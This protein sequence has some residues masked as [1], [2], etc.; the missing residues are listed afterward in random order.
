[1][2]DRRLS[3]RE[4]ARHARC[5]HATIR[6]A[7]RRGEIVAYQ[8]NPFSSAKNPRLRVKESGVDEFFEKA[9]FRTAT[10]TERSKA[11]RIPALDPSVAMVDAG[12]VDP[13][14]DPI[15]ARDVVR[16]IHRA[17]RLK[18]SAEEK[19]KLV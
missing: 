17:T 14:E 12:R 15:M 4:A 5:S 3:I 8:A 2:P 13:K 6:E 1:M 16:E 11:E 7:I 19:I 18:F 9:R 10:P